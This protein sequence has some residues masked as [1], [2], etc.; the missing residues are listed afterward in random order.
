MA[1]FDR[2]QMEVLVLDEQRKVRETLLCERVLL[3]VVEQ[4][5]FD[6]CIS[7]R[8]LT[9]QNF[10]SWTDTTWTAYRADATP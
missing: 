1:F 5:F 7:Y 6:V 8:I 3:V 10:A 2:V 4:E 9:H